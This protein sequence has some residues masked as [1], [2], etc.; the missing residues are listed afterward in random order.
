MKVVVRYPSIPGLD[1]VLETGAG[2]AVGDGLVELRTHMAM[3]PLAPGDV[4]RIDGEG[5]VT[6]VEHLEKLYTYEIDFHLPSP[7]MN[8]ARKTTFIPAGDPVLATVDRL[9]KEWSRDA[10]VTRF[11]NFTMAVSSQSMPWLEDKVLSSK[12]IENYELR[13][14]PDLK[15]DF[16][17]ARTHPDLDGSGGGPWA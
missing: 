5:T 16:A 17:V 13:R 2:L 10:W 11:T 7:E 12:L 4:V 6:G 1:D 3:I 8:A 9:E 14:T 15:L